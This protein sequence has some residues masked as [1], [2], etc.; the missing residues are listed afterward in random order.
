MSIGNIVDYKVAMFILWPQASSMPD[1]GAAVL[2]L[3]RCCSERQ[4]PVRRL[5]ASV[6]CREFFRGRNP[7]SR[8]EGRN[9]KRSTSF[10]KVNLEE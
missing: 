4:P 2:G 8:T 9:D 3:R 1:I 10:R 7:Q 5:P 6:G